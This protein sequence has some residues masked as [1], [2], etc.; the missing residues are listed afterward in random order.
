MT[1]ASEFPEKLAELVALWWDE[2]RRNDVLPL[3]NRVLDAIAHKHD[4]QKAAGD[5]P[6]LP[7]RS[8]GP[9]MGG[10][11]RPQP[12]TPDFGDGGRTRGRRPPGHAPRPR[13]RP[14]WL[15]APRAGRP[16]PLRPQPARATVVRHHERLDRSARA[17]ISS[18]CR[19]EKDE[20][21]GGVAT[22]L[23]DGEEVGSG[24]IDRFTPVAFNEVGVGLTCGYE[25]GPAVGSG[26]TAPFVFNGTIV[27]A[28]VTAT[29]PV[30]T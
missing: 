4:R 20:L 29:G 30:R 1:C 27:R 9:R 22:L 16:P 24:T 18:R 5:L 15:V 10:G 2:A 21:L 7:G 3:D 14:G 11:R 13:L 28:E 19:F 17:A 25:W 26:Y 6:L 23:Q 8:A 12:I